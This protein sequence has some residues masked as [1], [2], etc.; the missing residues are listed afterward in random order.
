MNFDDIEHI[1]PT[2]S[3]QRIDEPPT[4]FATPP[5]FITAEELMVLP[6]GGYGWRF[7]LVAGEVVWF[8]VGGVAHSDV[9][10]SLMM[11][12]G[13]YVEEHDLGTLLAPD[14]GFVLARNPDTVLAPDLSF[15]SYARLPR[16]E[17][18]DWYVPI[19]PDF[20]LEVV[21]DFEARRL[22]A[23]KVALYLSAGSRLVWVACPDTETIVAYAPG[24]APRLFGRDDWLDGGDVFPGFR[25]SAAEVFDFQKR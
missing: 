3:P 21:A 20:A 19:A 12:L 10:M 24:Q 6:G 14:T 23:T 11:P 17:I 4:T 1:T 5:R 9:E 16:S 8:P 22:F 7:E 25:V 15:V 18:D 13:Q 2:L